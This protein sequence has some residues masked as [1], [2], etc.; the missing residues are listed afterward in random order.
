MEVDWIVAVLV[1]LVFVGWS[2]SFYAAI[3]QESGNQL[4][5]TAIVERNKLMEHVSVD[6]YQIPVRY[7]SP[8]DVTDGVLK[9]GSIWYSGGKNTTRV[10][11]SSNNFPCIISGDELYW[12]DSISSGYN[13]YFIEMADLNEPMN[14][15]GSFSISSFNVTVPW[16]LEHRTM[17]SITKINEILN[18][19]YDDFREQ[20]NLNSDFRLTV[21]KASGNVVAGKSIP[22]GAIEV[23]SRSNEREIFETSEDA[24]ITIAIW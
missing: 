22:V 13:Y 2:F 19:S 10:F 24:N 14:C 20:A 1:F 16:A 15:S 3:F 21:Q 5:I 6:V 9:A 23:D 17:I 4:S 18:M 12:Q 11:M 8:G 7:N